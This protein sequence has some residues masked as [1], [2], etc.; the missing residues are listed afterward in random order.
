MAE[1]L[2]YVC[3]FCGS[4]VRVGKSCPGCAKKAKRPKRRFWEKEKYED[5][6]ERPDEDFNYDE[7]VAREFGKV[8]HRQTGL[9]WYWWALAVALLAAMIS[10]VWW[11]R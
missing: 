7:F 4:Q 10:S 11:S 2:S 8:P 5:G 9:R 3:P 1:I 6:L